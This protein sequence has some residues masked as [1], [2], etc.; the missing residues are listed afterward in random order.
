M[1]IGNDWKIKSNG[2]DLIVYRRIKRGEEY[3][4]APEDDPE[5]TD[6]EKGWKIHG[7][8][9]SVRNALKDLIDQE[10]RDADLADL[11]VL[12]ARLDALYAVIDG[13]PQSVLQKVGE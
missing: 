12:S 8:F 13:L 7:Y 1:L 4:T 10:V 6:K 11:R 5:A 9:R 2:L 3:E